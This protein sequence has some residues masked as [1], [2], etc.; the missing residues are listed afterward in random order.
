MS[1]DFPNSPAVGQTYPSP[2]VTGVPTYTWDG[3][4]WTTQGAGAIGKTAV[5]TDGSTSMTAALTLSGDPV[6]PT[7]AADKNYVDGKA[8]SVPGGSVMCFW[9]SAAPAGWT[10]VTTQ[11][12][13]ALRVVSGTGGVAGG[14]NA[15]STVMAQ[16]VTGNHTNALG[17]T[18]TGLTA[19][20]GSIAIYAYPGGNAS[21]GA[22]ISAGNSW[23]LITSANQAGYYTPYVSSNSGFSYTG[24]F[25]GANTISTA[26][27]NTGGGAHSHP[28]TLAIQY[29]DVILASKN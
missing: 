29:I 12:D 23:S 24:Q 2:P 26:S 15:F 27:N 17:D 19:S 14:A 4:K 11:N 16:S 28:I 25:Y 6:N 13:K 22:P 7:D 21:Y 8:G 1:L 3:Q 18:P 5:F 10:Q 20:S 9:Q